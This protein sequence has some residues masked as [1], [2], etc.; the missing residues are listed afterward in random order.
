M[1]SAVIP[2]VDSNHELLPLQFSLDPGDREDCGETM[3]LSQTDSVGLLKEY[4][5]VLT[6]DLHVSQVSLVSKIKAKTVLNKCC[7]VLIVCLFYVDKNDNGKVSLKVK[8][9]NFFL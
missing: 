1:L 7:V 6:V 5:D 3:Q 2:L 9:H 4:L 8:A